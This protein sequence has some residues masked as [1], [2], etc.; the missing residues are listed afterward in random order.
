MDGGRCAIGTYI[1]DMTGY[2]EDFL[3][4]VL[5]VIARMKYSLNFKTPSDLQ[6]NDHGILYS[7]I[8]KKRK[9]VYHLGLLSD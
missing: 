5:V 9:Q 3:R 6:I 4:A 8:Q 2:W 1:K 7:A